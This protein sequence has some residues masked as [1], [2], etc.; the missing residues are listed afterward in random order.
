MFDLIFCIAG[1]YACFLTWGVTQ[2]RVV[3]TDYGNGDK[4]RHFIVLNLVQAV[5]ASFVGFMYA[6]IVR[7]EEM[8]GLNRPLV[9]RIAILGLLVASASPFGYS[10]MKYLNYVAV[11]LAK[12]CKLLPIVIM[13]KLLYNRK[14]PL[15]KYAVVAMVTIGVSTFMLYQPAKKNKKATTTLEGSIF[16]LFLVLINLTL[17]GIVSSMQDQIFADFK[18]LR[19]EHMMCYVSLFSSIFML[20]WLLN[21]WNPELGQAISFFAAH[22]QVIGDIGLFAICGATGQCFIYYMLAH[23]GSLALTTTTVTRKL[24]TIL[25]SIAKFN[26]TLNPAQWGSIL[27]VFSGIALEAVMKTKSSKKLKEKT[28]APATKEENTQVSEEKVITYSSKHTQINAFDSALRSR[29]PIQS[30][31]Q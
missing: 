25:L 6:T 20:V 11:T 28:S 12:S 4:F 13:N 21:P 27:C 1:I 18:Y 30:S 5:V 17:D 15:Y 10:S 8:V 3:S 14:Y 19:G 2:E 31:S 26:H 7:K 29:Q 24:F 22:P 16:G 23:F 9:K